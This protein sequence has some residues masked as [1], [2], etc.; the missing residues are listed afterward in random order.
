VPIYRQ[1][2]D[3][4]LSGVAAGSL[5]PGMQLPT[6]RQTAVDL[7]VNLNTVARAYRDLEMRGVLN[8]QQ[9]SGTYIAKQVPTGTESS[10]EKR[11]AQI[12]QE[13][14]AQAGKEGFTLGELLLALQ[15]LFPE[16]RENKELS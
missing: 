7:S 3:Q 9:G 10:R 13:C 6:V 14:A 5:Q 1:I 8:T 2:I 12:A 4:V 15:A 16:Q 11:L